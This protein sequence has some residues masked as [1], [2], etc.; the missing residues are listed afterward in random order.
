MEDWAEE[1]LKIL[2]NSG[3]WVAMAGGYVDDGR[4]LMSMLEKGSRFDENEKKFVFDKDGFEE[5]A[6]LEKAGESNNEFMARI[7]I[8]AMNSVNKDLK[9]TTETP[10]HFEKERLPTLDF[11]LWIEK[12]TGKVHH[13]YFQ[14]QMKT[15]FIL[16]ARS[17]MCNHQKIQINSHICELGGALPPFGSNFFG[18]ADRQSHF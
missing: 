4:K 14:K 1:F 13:S 16:M 8:K 15:P 12:E 7:L 11:E 17:A 2:V 10:E 3:I 6:R 5:D 9:F 18:H